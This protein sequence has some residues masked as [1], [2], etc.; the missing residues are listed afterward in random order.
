MGN[1][2]QIAV[3]LQD[4]S[5]YVSREH[6]MWSRQVKIYTT[7][8]E[9]SGLTRS[10][11]EELKLVPDTSVVEYTYVPTDKDEMILVTVSKHFISLEM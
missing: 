7:V 3:Y 6:N 4:G 9:K 8:K 1:V 2:V 10:F 5:P 11:P